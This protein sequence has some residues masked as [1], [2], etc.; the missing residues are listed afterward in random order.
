MFDGGSAVWS[1]KTYARQTVYKFPAGSFLLAAR[2]YNSAG[3]S[4]EF[5]IVNLLVRI[6]LIIELISVDRPCAMGV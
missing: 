2:I 1:P 5:F 3:Y 6:N 4:R